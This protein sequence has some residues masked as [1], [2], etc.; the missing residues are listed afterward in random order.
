LGAALLKVLVTYFV[1]TCIGLVS[2]LIWSFSETRD[3]W[4]ASDVILG[5]WISAIFA[6]PAFLFVGLP[7]LT[8]GFSSW[9]RSHLRAFCMAGAGLGA[10]GGCALGALLTMPEHFPAFF[11][12]VGGIAGASC[13]FVWARMSV[14]RG[15][16]AIA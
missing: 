2:M 13:A 5:F 16:G 14:R 6:L 8:L 12:I 7:F 15:A 1:A 10:I 3:V 4:T 11:P 9:G